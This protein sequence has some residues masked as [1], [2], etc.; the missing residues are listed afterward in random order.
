VLCN[1]GTQPFTTYWTTAPDPL[2]LVGPNGDKLLV[3]LDY[4][5][6]P[7]VPT[8][9]PSGGDLWTYIATATPLAGQ[10]GASSGAYTATSDY[11]VAF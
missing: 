1:S 6:D 4:G 2:A 8:A 9:G 10:F 11:V 3:T 7:T 5:T